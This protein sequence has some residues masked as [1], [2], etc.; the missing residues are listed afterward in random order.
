TFRSGPATAGRLGALVDKLVIDVEALGAAYDIALPSDMLSFIDLGA[1]A[2]DTTRQLL[3]DSD[4]DWPVGTAFYASN[5]KLLAPIP[6]PRKNIFGI[7]L[8]YVEH[9]AESA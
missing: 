5:V 1:A 3:E 8:N 6:R 7:G 9:V 2:L 4:G